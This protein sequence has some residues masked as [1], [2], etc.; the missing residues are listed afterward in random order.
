MDKIF[1]F[2]MCFYFCYAKIK[3]NKLDV[4]SSIRHG[5]QTEVVLDC[6]FDSGGDTVTEIKW[7]LDG[8]HQIYQWLPGYN[9][10]GQALGKL[11][12]NI[13]TSYQVTEDEKTMYR[14]LHITDLSPELSGNYTC[15]VSGPMSEDVKTKRMIIYEAPDTG[16]DLTIS[17][18]NSLIMCTAEGFYPQP[19]M[20]IYVNNDNE[21]EIYQEDAET[22][23]LDDSG[24]FNVSST[25]TYDPDALTDIFSYTCE[26][27]IPGTNF[28][29]SETRTHDQENSSETQVEEELNLFNST[30]S[31]ESSFEE[32]K[33]RWIV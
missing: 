33:G 14:A 19:N 2:L 20:T 30:N 28:N 6:D 24:L 3:I 11:K 4:P 21:T 22:I 16:L 8:D 7:F 17:E 26:L 29:L 13:D 31:T 25:L 5:D 12:K 9:K 1:L 10:A 15:K 27:N 23:E 18:E 32:S